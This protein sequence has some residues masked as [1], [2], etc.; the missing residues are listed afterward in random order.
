MLSDLESKAGLHL[1]EAAAVAVRSQAN[2]K[3]MLPLG[4]MPALAQIMRV[5]VSLEHPCKQDPFLGSNSGK[6]FGW[7]AG[8]E[9]QYALSHQP[10]QQETPGMQWL[11]Q[12][13][14][15]A[16]FTPSTSVVPAMTMCTVCDSGGAE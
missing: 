16:A 10:L 7:P 1:L 6:H 4:L 15:I 14:G 2:R 3:Q 12:R 9:V 5:S 13:T 8:P 11:P